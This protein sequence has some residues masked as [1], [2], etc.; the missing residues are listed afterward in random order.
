MDRFPQ[1]LVAAMAGVFPRGNPSTDSWQQA[2]GRSLEIGAAEAPN[3]DNLAM[4]AMFAV[5]KAFDGVEGSLRHVSSALGQ[6]RDDRRQLQ[7]DHNADIE[8]LNAE[9][10]RLTRQRN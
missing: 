5:T 3:S 4:S 7:R 9:M 8:R 2:R 6:A 1:E 10:A